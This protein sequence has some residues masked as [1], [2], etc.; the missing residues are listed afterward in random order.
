M[1]KKILLGLILTLTTAFSINAQD[2]D[3][4]EKIAGDLRLQADDL[5]SRTNRSIRKEGTHSSDEI[6]NAF[7]AE[8]L[9]ASTI[10]IKRLI[11]DQYRAS[12]VRYAGMVLA[13][14]S[15]KFPVKGE[16]RFEWKKATDTI[17]ELSRELR[18]LNTGVNIEKAG[19]GVDD[20]SILGKAV[21]SGMVDADVQL[22][23]K[24]D[25]ILVQ[26]MSG[27]EYAAG[28]YSFSAKIP[29]QSRIRVGVK[30]K[31]GRGKAHVMQQPDQSNNYTAIIQVRD[32]E[33]GA[34][35]YSLEIYWY[36]R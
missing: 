28:A 6:E 35:P 16:N 14:L 29:R 11:E 21:W 33:G 36:R 8:Q 19:Y 23:V 15:E 1:K 34:K 18:G 22:T 10:L 20:A 5:V 25:K 31:N 4:L 9:R 13:D 17:K 3:R 32:E 2:F 26:T 12:E 30:I 27:R 24:G 7:L